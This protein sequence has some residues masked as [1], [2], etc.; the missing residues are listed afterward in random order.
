MKTRSKPLQKELENIHPKKTRKF[1]NR[2][3]SSKTRSKPLERTRESHSEQGANHSK[4]IRDISCKDQAAR[5]GT[6]AIRKKEHTARKRAQNF[7]RD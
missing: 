4:E 6:R 7:E 2:L 3:E 1:R 5:K